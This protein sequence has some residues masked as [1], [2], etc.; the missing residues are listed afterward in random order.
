[1]RSQQAKYTAS[2]PWQTTHASCCVGGMAM[3]PAP[4]NNEWVTF[5]AWFTHCQGFV[6]CREQTA[7]ISASSQCQH[8]HCSAH[9]PL[10]V[11]SEGWTLDTVIHYPGSDLFSRGN[12][13]CSHWIFLYGQLV[14]TAHCKH[15]PLR[16]VTVP[17]LLC[18]RRL[19]LCQCQL[20]KA[21][22]AGV[23]AGTNNNDSRPFSSP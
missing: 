3:R 15:N 23:E 12:I 8:Q 16:P 18:A 9:H 19:P 4:T 22:K 10:S 17:P 13:G 1:M 20:E 6:I 2:I 11:S 21:K 5:A 7:P 14:I